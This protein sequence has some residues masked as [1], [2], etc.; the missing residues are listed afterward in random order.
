MY[1]NTNCGQLTPQMFKSCK[2]D[3][4]PSTTHGHIPYFNKMLCQWA[5]SV[6]MKFSWVMLIIAHNKDYLVNKIKT[7]VPNYEPPGWKVDG[8]VD[9]TWTNATQDVVGC[10][11]AQGVDIPGENVNIDYAGV[12]EGSNRGFINAPIVNG[13]SN[14]E[15]LGAGFLE[16]NKS[17]TDGVLRPWSILV[18]HEGLIATPRNK[19]IKADILIY[20]L[21]KNGECSPNIIRKANK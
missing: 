19:S 4:Q 6:P 8:M 7:V 9:A 15:P 17:F 16:T 1:V 14:F 5:Y 2:M 10:I 12:S 21:A 3:G 11:F 13:R 20:Q 18:A